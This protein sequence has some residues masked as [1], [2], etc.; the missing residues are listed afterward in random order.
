MFKNGYGKVGKATH[1]NKL[2][3]RVAYE[4][5]NG[6]IPDGLV[7]DHLCRNRRC[8]NPSHL[9][10]V[11][12]LENLRRGIGYRLQNGMDASCVN[13][14]LYTEENT[15]VNPNRRNDIRCRACA[16]LLNRKRTRN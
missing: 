15:Y 12:S 1:H 3:H 6:A 11:S 4:I 16:R 8:V 10:P 2:A 14:H 9:E 7:L 13:G 5:A